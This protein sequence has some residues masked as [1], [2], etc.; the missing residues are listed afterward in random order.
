MGFINDQLYVELCWAMLIWLIQ[1]TNNFAAF[2]FDPN[3]LAIQR[4]YRLWNQSTRLNGKRW[5]SKK[6]AS[7][8]Q[9]FF[10]CC[11]HSTFTNTDPTTAKLTRK[12]SRTIDH[13]YVYHVVSNQIPL[14]F[15][16]QKQMVKHISFVHICHTS[17]YMKVHIYIIIYILSPT[18]NHESN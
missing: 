15:S 2:Q 8:I 16:H 13:V 18:I 5:N 10:T 3:Q 1:G 6:K 17:A 12:K 7:N 4:I 9:Y 14:Q 11:L